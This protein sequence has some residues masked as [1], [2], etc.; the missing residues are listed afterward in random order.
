MCEGKW[1]AEKQISSWRWWREVGAGGEYIGRKTTKWVRE[2]KSRQK[3]P[4]WKLEGMEINLQFP[5][6]MV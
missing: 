3:A 4:D 6:E 2:K 5:H 1:I